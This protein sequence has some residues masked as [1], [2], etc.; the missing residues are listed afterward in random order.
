MID[1]HLLNSFEQSGMTF[2]T[3]YVPLSIFVLL[4]QN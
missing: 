3:F 4:F 2:A 1:F